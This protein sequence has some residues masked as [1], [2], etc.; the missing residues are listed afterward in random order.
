MGWVEV[1]WGKAVSCNTLCSG[2]VGHLFLVRIP[3]SR[4]P[5]VLLSWSATSDSAFQFSGNYFL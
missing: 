3:W 5:N 4:T 2:G 1:T